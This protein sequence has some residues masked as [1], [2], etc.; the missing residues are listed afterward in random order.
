MLLRLACNLIV[1][2]CLGGAVLGGCASTSNIQF[3]QSHPHEPVK[4]LVTQSP[5]TID[6]AR[7]QKVFAPQSKKKLSA[8]ATPISLDIKHAEQHAL[9]RLEA[10]LGKQSR[11]A[12]LTAPVADKPLLDQIKAYPY[13]TLL[14]QDVA[15]RIQTSTGADAILRFKITDYGLTPRSWR[16]GY[17][18]FEVTSTLAITALIASAGTSLAKGAAGAYLGQEAVEETAE[19]YAGFWALD[20]VC[21]PVRIE[22]ELIRLHPVGVVWQDDDTGLADVKFSRL[23]RKIGS[24]ER[25]MQLDQSTDYAV[26]DIVSDLAEALGPF[27]P[28]HPMHAFPNGR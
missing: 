18:T 1:I 14:P 3:D 2:F 22:A 13:D 9:V 11:L 26:N 7:L 24:K 28:V 23:T 25:D 21:R 19:G 5:V 15:D 16:S 10:D 20:V 17:V 12:M 4:I 6:P 8:S 27:K